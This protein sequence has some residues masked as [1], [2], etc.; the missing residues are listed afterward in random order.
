MAF[1]WTC[2][3]ELPVYVLFVGRR[4]ERWWSVCVLALLLN[5]ATH[6]ALWHLFPRFGPAAL[7]LMIAE[8]TVIGI[9]ALLVAV[10]LARSMPAAQAA[11][12]GLLASLAA[13]AFST[14]AGLLFP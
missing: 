3:L 6:P 13:N 14:G 10:V 1:L 2:A 11:G 7:W 12:L 9:E 4:L 8:S 5:V